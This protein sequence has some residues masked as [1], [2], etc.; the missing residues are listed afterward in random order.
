MMRM[1]VIML[2]VLS[3]TVEAGVLCIAKRGLGPVTFHSETCPRRLRQV[4][5]S[6]LPGFMTAGPAG[7]QG[8]SGPQGPIGAPGPTGA[9]GPTGP[10]GTGSG[11]VGPTGP[12]GPGGPTGAQGV[13]GPIGPTGLQ[14]ALGPTGSIGPTGPTGFVASVTQVFGATQF[15]LAPVAGTAFNA[16]ANCG[17]QRL[18][19]G[20]FAL[21]YNTVGEAAAD[22]GKFHLVTNQPDL[23]QNMW[24]T[25][26]FVL[27]NFSPSGT[28]QLQAY[29]L[30]AP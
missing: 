23:N 13:Q 2:L 19:G 7:A 15:A 9:Q 29:A 27:Q 20:G 24:V 30:C 3:S 18:I 10:S 16:F 12:Q 26:G 14:G 11:G 17:Q 8:P 4:Q 21:N 6:E 5:P 28:F 1:I 22:L 25:S